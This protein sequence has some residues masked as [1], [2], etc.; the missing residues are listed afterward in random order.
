MNQDGASSGLTVPNGLAQ[1]AVIRQALAVAQVEPGDVDYV[2]AHGTG[3]ALGDPIEIEAL[4]AVL[5]EGRAADRPLVV[6]SVKTNIGHPESA[7]GVAGLIK[8]VL[9]LQHN[10]IPPHLHFK[11]LNPNITTR[12]LR[13]LVPTSAMPWPVGSASRIAGVS[14]FG[15]SGTNAHVIVEEA[16]PVER[17]VGEAAPRELLPISARSPSALRALAGRLADHLEARP[18]QSLEDICVTARHGR[19]QFAAPCR[20]RRRITR[21]MS[22][23]APSVRGNRK[24]SRRADRALSG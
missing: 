21:R 10:E 12:R 24:C 3:T 17:T 16:P 5:S 8:T 19:A 23:Q 20:H 6:G 14:S 2:E 4:D 18:D 1:Q 9:A 15:F 22:R 7:A 11:T 13:L